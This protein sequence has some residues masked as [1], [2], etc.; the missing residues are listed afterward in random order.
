MNT[1]N[2]SSE[3]IQLDEI[4]RINQAKKFGRYC[5]KIWKID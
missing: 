1:K 5:Q 2:Y 3:T 4:F